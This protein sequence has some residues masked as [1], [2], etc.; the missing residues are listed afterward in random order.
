[1]KSAILILVFSALLSFVLQAQLI[2][3]TEYIG[4]SAY[5]D[6]KTDEKVSNYK[7]ASVIYQADL[8]L[9]LSLKTNENGLP[10]MW[11]I[12]SGVAYAR[13]YN[14]NFREDL[15]TDE[16]FNLYAGILNILPINRKWVMASSIGVGIYSPTPHLSGIIDKQLLANAALLFICNVRLNLQL[17]AGLAFNNTFG[18]MMV[19]PAFYL[20]WSTTGRWDININVSSGF[21]ASGGYHFNERFALKLLLEVKGQM[22]FLQKDGKDMMFSHQYMVSGFRPEFRVGKYLSIPLVA[23][24]NIMRMASYNK[25]TLKAMFVSTEPGGYFQVSPYFSAGFSIGL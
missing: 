20:K 24:V 1:M 17:G 25:R 15:V 6:E 12:T 9:P 4:R 10:R 8:N 18:Y 13:L 23:G 19:F 5:R 11:A 3:K 2:I 22:A 16:I 7:G 21:E 14:Q